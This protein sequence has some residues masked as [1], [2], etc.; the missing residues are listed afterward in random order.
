MLDRELLQEKLDSS[1]ISITFIADKM[2]ISRGT[3]YNRMENGD[4]KA[5]E[6]LLL[7]D[8]L[9]LNNDERE[10]IFLRQSGEGESGK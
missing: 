1:G 7:S 3:F 9:Q 10:E 6:I 4:Y 5:S 8:I 2:G